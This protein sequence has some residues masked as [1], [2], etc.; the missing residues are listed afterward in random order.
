MLRKTVFW[1]LV[2]VCLL[3]PEIGGFAQIKES[4]GQNQTA[5][6]AASASTGLRR[7]RK[8]EDLQ[9]DVSQ[10][11]DKSKWTLVNPEPIYIPS[12][13]EGL[14]AAVTPEMIAALRR[15]A[16]HDG[17]Y[18]AVF[19]NKIGREIMF[20]NLSQPFPEGTVIVKKKFQPYYTGNFD[21][22]TQAQPAIAL[23]TVMIKRK[24]GYNPQAGDWEFA[25]VSAD[26]QTV[27][28]SG[29]LENCM[30]CHATQK[31]T[32]FIFRTYL[33]RPQTTATNRP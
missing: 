26:G 32:N 9:L 29:K 7:D 5:N 6:A 8:Q 1:F 25:A 13:L 16:P 19:V 27:E 22:Y 23:Y 3:G 12:G 4:A 21:P 30:R 10:F 28:A 31:S 2:F 14:C 33:T 11:K 24:P 17:T 20:S 15:E 18:I